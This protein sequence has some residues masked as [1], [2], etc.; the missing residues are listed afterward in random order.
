MQR[1]PT[2]RLTARR[3]TLRGQ[4]T[5]LGPVLRA[6]VVERFTQCGKGNCKCMRGEKHGPAYYL[7]V[8]YA[9]GRT[10]QVYIPKTLRPVA[11]TWVRNYRQALDVLE[12]VSSINLELLRR[13]TPEAE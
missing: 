11:E 7:A 6:T 3:H 10:R 4:L 13:K 5:R 9:K 2:R 1:V 12:E 8:S